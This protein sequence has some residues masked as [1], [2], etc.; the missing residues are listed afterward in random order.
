MAPQSP[1][2]PVESFPPGE[3]RNQATQ[4]SPALSDSDGQGAGK[5]RQEG[6]GLGLEK[7]LE[8]FCG[9]NICG[10]PPV[11]SSCPV[12]LSCPPVLSSRDSP[13]E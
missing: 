11:L 6:L 10:L 5:G 2:W 12:L 13:V 8:E 3:M 1:R 4:T 7:V 9:R